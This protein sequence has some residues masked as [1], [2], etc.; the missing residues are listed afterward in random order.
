MENN[1]MKRQRLL[2]LFIRKTDSDN[3]IIHKVL[4]KTQSH[5]ELVIRSKSKHNFIPK[6]SFLFLM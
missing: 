6:A 5:L 3:L 2:F 1:N 4:T